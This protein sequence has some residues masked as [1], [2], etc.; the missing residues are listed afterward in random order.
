MVT[1]DATLHQTKPTQNDGANERLMLGAVPGRGSEDRIVL[2]FDG[3]A[4]HSI[5]ADTRIG[6]VYLLLTPEPDENSAATRNKN[7]TCELSL[8]AYPLSDAFAEGNGNLSAGDSGDGVGATWLCAADRDIQDNRNQCLVKWSHPF[9][10]RTEGT[11]ATQFESSPAPLAW[12]VTADIKRGIH[13]WVIKRQSN[14]HGC[15][16]IKA[17]YVTTHERAQR[18]SPIWA[19]R[20]ACS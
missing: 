13:R 11:N 16:G 19:R 15:I 4:L 17:I 18:K 8:T 14:S 10:N 2:S 12:N 5:L 6:D 9:V 3:D 20:L 7:K 1:A